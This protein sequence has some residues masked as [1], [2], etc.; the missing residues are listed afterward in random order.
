[1]NHFEEGQLIKVHAHEEVRNRTNEAIFNIITDRFQSNIV[2]VV[3]T[4]PDNSYVTAISNVAGDTVLRTVDFGSDLD[5]NIIFN[6][7]DQ[8]NGFIEFV[9]ADTFGNLAKLARMSEIYSQI[10]ELE[11]ASS[12]ISELR[13]EYNKLQKEVVLP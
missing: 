6:V 10:L 1:M 2:R 4:N 8:R 12:K 5:L 3:E 7:H 13:A 11:K 9:A